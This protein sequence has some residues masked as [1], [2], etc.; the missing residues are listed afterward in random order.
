M[1]RKANNSCSNSANEHFSQNTKS[2]INQSKSRNKRM[3]CEYLKKCARI[4][5]Y[6]TL[7]E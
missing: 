6:F 2:K 7:V 5:L 1:I 3:Q 4:F